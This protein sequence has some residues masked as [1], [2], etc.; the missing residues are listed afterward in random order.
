MP[1]VE[2]DCKSDVL[3]LIAFN[4]VAVSAATEVFERLLR[5][6]DEIPDI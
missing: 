4:S 3:R 6:P 5:A 1:L 2:S